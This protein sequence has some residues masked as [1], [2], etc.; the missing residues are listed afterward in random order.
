MARGGK[1]KNSGRPTIGEVE[2][3]LVRIPPKVKEALRLQ[4]IEQEKSVNSLVAGIL[5][6]AVGISTEAL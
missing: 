4:A 2:A 6:K 3:L 1:R 5:G